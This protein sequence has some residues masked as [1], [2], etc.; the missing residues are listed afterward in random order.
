MLLTVEEVVEVDVNQFLLQQ[1]LADLFRHLST[2]YANK[3]E[4]LHVFVV[5]SEDFKRQRLKVFENICLIW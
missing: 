3:K 4:T 5:I 2:Q 1:I